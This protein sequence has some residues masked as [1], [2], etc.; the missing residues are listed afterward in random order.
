MSICKYKDVRKSLVR[1][2]K[3]GPLT[4]SVSRITHL[5]IHH[6]A[7][8]QGLAGSNAEAFARFHVQNNG[9]R[10]IAYAYVIEPDGTTKH[11]LDHNIN[12]PHVGNH[13]AY[14]I[15]VCLTGD[16][17]K[18]KP[19]K[20]QEKALRALVA[21]L[22]KAIPSIKYI[23]GH[24]EMA[25]YAWKNC[26]AFDY[27][28]VLAASDPAPAP[29]WTQEELDRLNSAPNGARFSRTLKYIRGNQMTGNDILAVQQFLGV[30]PARDKNGK[31]Y[32]IFGPKIEET[33]KKWQQKNGIKVTGEVGIVNWRRMFGEKKEVP[34]PTPDDSKPGPKPYIRVTVN[35]KQQHAFEQKD[36]AIKW[37]TDTVKAGI[38]WIL[39][40][41]FR[42][43]GGV[44]PV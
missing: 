18:E 33:L 38:R 21:Y 23:R 13:N 12:G 35:G 11:C 4:R 5:V 8:R 15:G 16:F 24:Q 14:S 32:G 31:V 2:T 26:P 27:K 20:E 7:T 10:N 29:K 36:S 44:I 40:D 37:F 34:K 3:R 39:N 22:R 1:D 28:K 30:T 17:A 43:P 42:K 25:G 9:W 19:T 41:K 6:S